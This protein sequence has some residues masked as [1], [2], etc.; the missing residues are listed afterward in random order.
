M[1]IIVILDQAD[2]KANLR[3]KTIDT[4][5]L[6]PSARLLGYSSTQYKSFGRLLESG[7]SRSIKK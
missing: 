5:P 6:N 4:K 3:C 2:M 1:L 7:D